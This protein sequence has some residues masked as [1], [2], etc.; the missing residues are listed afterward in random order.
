MLA[1]TGPGRGFGT[2]AV[3]LLLWW[4]CSI[5]VGGTPLTAA[6]REVEW[7]PMTQQRL[8][9]AEWAGRARLRTGTAEPDDPGQGDATTAVE[10][11]WSGAGGVKLPGFI[12]AGGIDAGA[13]E[14]LVLE[15]FL[16][17]AQPAA[18]DLML[19]EPDRR[20]A[21]RRKV[22]IVPDEWLTVEVPLRWMRWDQGR[23]PRWSELRDLQ[24]HTDGPGLVVRRIGWLQGPNRPGALPVAAEILA[25]AFGDQEHPVQ[26]FDHN[27]LRVWS[28]ATADQVDVTLLG[29]HLA[30]VRDRVVEEW[31]L[32]PE[33]MDGRPPTLLVFRDRAGYREFVPRYAA[34]L[35][36]V[37]LRPDSG[38]YHLQGWALSWFDP[39]FGTLRPVF[40]HEFV[41]S[42]L[43][44]HALI[45]GSRSDWFHEGIA[46]RCQ[47]HFH[48]QADLGEI[49]RRGLRRGALPLRK[50][51]DGGNL[52]M[53]H[54]WQAMSVVDW[55]V[56][57]GEVDLAT[58]QALVQALREA[59]DTALGPHL[60]PVLGM[61]WSQFESAW[62]QWNERRWREGR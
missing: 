28:A 10:I 50:L 15:V 24:L 54:Y 59:G 16:H 52:E 49:V 12:D 58:R 19:S 48:P 13:V 23:V 33:P 34:A 8:Q 39:R 7:V 47:M 57:S 43:A 18:I 44:H 27:G 22:E 30:E 6:E 17:G 37:A 9:G 29:R 45:D 2:P 14:A 20:A 41:H 42:V 11:V 56:D 32:P 25:L 4:A 3:A 1:W 21:F 62:R 55:L 40:T 61:D 36:A 46:V 38:G 5:G 31:G 53:R 51:C 60:R 26:R 35:G